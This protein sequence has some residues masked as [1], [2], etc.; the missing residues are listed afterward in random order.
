M[1]IKVLIKKLGAI[2]GSLVLIVGIIV[3]DVVCYVHANEITSHLCPDKIVPNTKNQTETL[4]E[5]DKIVQRIAEEGITLLKNEN[6]TLPLDFSEV[7]KDNPYN[8]NLFG[9]GSTDSDEN[10]FFVFGIG[11]GTVSLEK[12]NTVFL[13]QGL[14]NNGFAVNDMLYNYFRDAKRNPAADW[15][16]K[17]SS[18]T[19]RDYA[20]VFSDTAIVTISRITGENRGDRAN[21]GDTVVSEP[22]KHPWGATYIDDEADGRNFCQISVNEEAMIKWCAENFENVIVIVNSG[23]VMEL[24]LLDEL[25]G[26]DAV[27]YV[28]H[29]GQSGANAIGKILNGEVNPSGKTTDTFAYFTTEN[30]PYAADAFYQN[31]ANNS[32]HIAYTEDI[33]IG[34]KWYET[35]D[36]EGFFASKGTSYDKVVQYPFGYGLSYTS[37]EWTIK[38]VDIKKS[39]EEVS[40][41]LKNGDTV[42][43]K[44][45]KITVAV[46]VKNTGSVAG[47]D[48]VQ[49]YMTAPYTK[50]KIEK[51]YVALTDFVKTE[52]L[53]P[54]SEATGDKKNTEIVTLEFDLYD[55]ASYDCY[56]KNGNGFK[57]YEL[58]GGNY[59]MSLRNDAHTVNACE[60]AEYSFKIGE[61]GFKFEKDPT[62]GYTVEN[63]FTGET[64][65][66]GVPIDGSNGTDE[67]IVYLSRADFEG[68]YPN[69]KFKVRTKGY[70]ITRGKGISAYLDDGVYYKDLAMPTFNAER[71]LFLYTLEDGS[72]ATATDL[73]G[74]G[75]KIKIN[76]QLVLKLGEDYNA[77]EW[78]QL[79]SQLTVSDVKTVVTRCSLGTLA[80]ES[81]G[82]PADKVNDGPAGINN[83]TLSFEQME[84]VSAF[85]CEAL[86]GMT[87]NKD[88][89]REMGAAM[90]KEVSGLARIG[91]YA[92]ALD[93]H[94]HP[95]NG[96]NFEQFGE[97]PVLVAKLGAKEVYGMTTHGIQ[98]SI[99]HFIISTPGMNP[100]YYNSWITEQN[101]RES[102][103]RAFEESVKESKANFLMTSFNN[104]G[105]VMCATSYA[106]NTEI[107]RNEWGFVGSVI[108]DYNVTTREKTTANIIRSGNDLRFMNSASN[109]AELDETNAVDMALGVRSVKNSLYSFCN[110]YYRTKNYNPNYTITSY[111]TIPTFNWWIPSLVILNVLIFGAV[112]YTIVRSF[113]LK[114]GRAETVELINA[115][116][117]KNKARL[118]AKSVTSVGAELVSEEAQQPEQVVAAATATAAA[119]AVASVPEHVAPVATVKFDTLADENFF[120]GIKYQSLCLLEKATVAEKDGDV[121]IFEKGFKKVHLMVENGKTVAYFYDDNVILAKIKVVSEK[122][123][124]A[125]TELIG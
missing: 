52:T 7:D 33:Y 120:F 40:A 117:G 49:L 62:T 35:A 60:N 99:K 26:V 76:E 64:A 78:E 1:N 30:A 88:L 106:L 43:D 69:T 25:D 109:L 51:P 71:K 90:A 101:L 8:V 65:E 47:K 22:W 31:G 121:M 66:A 29:T 63:R 12:E 57:G 37:F 84:N 96:R 19:Y 27:M 113:V 14:E 2:L 67:N 41:A 75:K 54:E 119:T 98:C 112:A 124:R 70:D 32:K 61:S 45:S 44:N 79:L 17:D 6:N 59:I 11:S 56:D 9:V 91:L 125:A 15:W 72:P 85:P 24:G 87:W 58:D 34:Y 95:Y 114:K 92:P 28:P 73:A 108:T 104:I 46:E 77:P 39:G 42:T 23:N 89:L 18:K 53:Y 102:Y 3:G 86:A 20:K 115:I 97:D 111:T 122:T 103:L 68:T 50:G 116:F 74:K 48:V 21:S 107:L 55:I 80:A 100:H 81:I 94:R 105:G 82:K 123:Y 83:V 10:G 110:T 38:S 5:S 16:T 118:A 93:V 4:A 13:R 36:K